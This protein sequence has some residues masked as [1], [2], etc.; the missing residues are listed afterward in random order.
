MGTGRRRRLGTG[1]DA[2]RHR[3][4]GRA[5][6]D[7]PVPA[8]RRRPDRRVARAPQTPHGRQGTLLLARV[9]HHLQGAHGHRPAGRRGRDPDRPQGIGHL[10]AA[11]VPRRTRSQFEFRRLPGCDGTRLRARGG[12]RHRRRFGLSLRD[13]LQTRGLLRPDGRARHAH[14]RH[15]GHLRRPV[16]D[17]AH[18]RPHPLGGL[19]RDGR[20][21]HAVAHAARGRK[22]HGLD[23]CQ[24]L[25]H[26]AARRARLVET[27]PRRCETRLRT[28]LRRG[29][30]RSRGTAVDRPEQQTRLPP[31]ARRGVA[32]T[33]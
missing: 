3:G 32:R 11:D 30:H 9:R 33:A 27:L 16:R 20:G 26:G 24:L 4:G 23:V 22:R 12:P 5:R 6:H 17:A 29:G 18:T 8:L 31:E 2:L 14:G 1:A 10:A 13:R 25:D 15:P 7:H 19:Q 28:A 21:A